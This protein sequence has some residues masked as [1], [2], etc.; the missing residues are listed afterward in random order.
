MQPSPNEDTVNPWPSCRCFT[1]MPPCSQVFTPDWSPRNSQFERP[2]GKI[3][4]GRGLFYR[5]GQRR[6]AEGGV[7]PL[8]AD[9]LR[10]LIDAHGAALV[11]YA[12]QWCR[13]PDDALQESLMELLRQERPPE[14]P[15]AWLFKTVRRRAMNL[16][17]GERRRA[18]HHQRAGREREPWFVDGA[19]DEFDSR[20]LAAMLERLPPLERE[21]VVARVWGDLSFEQ[22]AELVGI[23]T[24]AAH[25]RYHSALSLLGHMIEEEPNTSGPNDGRAERITSRP[26]A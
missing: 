9:R 7:E 17:R 22:V 11:L 1:A 16:A 8:D 25:R 5:R 13:A 12:R 14:H 23:S 19:E 20:G 21:I 4:F 26:D 2:G 10:R 3:E 24:S 18:K 6:A 15:E